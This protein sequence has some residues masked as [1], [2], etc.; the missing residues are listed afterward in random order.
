MS[1]FNDFPLSTK[2]NGKWTGEDYVRLQLVTSMMNATFRIIEPEE[3]T[4]DRMYEDTMSGVTDFC[5]ISHYLM[6]YLYRDADCSYPHQQNQIV[7][8]IPLKQESM[9]HNH[10]LVS[11]FH[12]VVWLLFIVSVVT[13]ST[14]TLVVNLVEKRTFQ[15]NCLEYFSISLG[16]PP[17]SLDRQPIVLKT[18]STI[19]IFS[20]IIFLTAFQCSLISTFVTPRVEH[21]IKTISEF[22]KSRFSIYT[23]PLLANMIP[24]EENLTDRIFNISAQERNNMLYSLDTRA[25]HVV[26]WTYAKT[27]TETLK[28]RYAKPPFYIM[29]E[30]LVPGVDAYFFQRHSPYLEKINECL[31]RQKQYALSEIRI[32]S[33]SSLRGNITRNEG[34]QTVLGMKHLHHVFHLLVMGLFLSVVVFV[35]EII[36]KNGRKFIIWYKNK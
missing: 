10:G 30:A 18:S 23:T 17:F 19:F 27:F 14:V 36:L 33:G 20:C 12:P 21:E 29:E 32:H 15:T 34:S 9:F 11:I 7:V 35:C 3:F 5:F 16:Q 4:H 8:L 25:A 13:L 28:N 1:F 24:P 22:R 31:L 6:E 26:M 2:L